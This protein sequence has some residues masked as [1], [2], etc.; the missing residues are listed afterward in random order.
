MTIFYT[1]TYL[2]HLLF[3]HLPSLVLCS[4]SI[5]TKGSALASEAGEG[6]RK[7]RKQLEKLIVRIHRCYIMLNQN[8]GKDLHQHCKF[9]DV[10]IS[11]FIQ[12]LYKNSITHSGILML[13]NT[14]TVS[15][16]PLFIRDYID[17][18]LYQT[19]NIYIFF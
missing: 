17:Y 3:L 12:K 4:Y 18:H 16:V 2:T 10:I 19:K 1:P 11:L 8:Q 9:S 14:Y 6:A 5:L 15:S 7:A 13:P